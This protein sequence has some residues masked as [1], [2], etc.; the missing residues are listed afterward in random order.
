MR[1]NNAIKFVQY[2]NSLLYFRNETLPQW[3]NP[4]DSGVAGVRS[5]R[6]AARWIRSYANGRAT[7]V[8]Y[9]T[10]RLLAFSG[11]HTTLEPLHASKLS[12]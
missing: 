12:A 9:F 7:G 4:R 6:W 5:A 3:L 10:I 2:P 8:A 1:V 11:L